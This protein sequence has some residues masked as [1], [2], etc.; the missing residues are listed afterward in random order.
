MYE[1]KYES[2]LINAPTKLGRQDARTAAR[3][4]SAPLG[5]AGGRLQCGHT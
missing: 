4:R 3:V 5:H 2:K 1:Y